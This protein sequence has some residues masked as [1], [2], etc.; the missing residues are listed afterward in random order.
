MMFGVS[1]RD[2]RP[3]AF[4]LA[5]RNGLAH[6]FNTTKLLAGNH[7]YYS[8]LKR[9]PELSLRQPEATSIARFA[10]LTERQSATF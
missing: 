3:L 9:H 2:L 1:R 5:A 10:V 8:F 4:Q 7:W 6:A